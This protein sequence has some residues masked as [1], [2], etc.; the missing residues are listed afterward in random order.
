MAG[1][2]DPQVEEKS[3][4]EADAVKVKGAEAALLD[5]VPADR[6]AAIEASVTATPAPRSREDLLE[7]AVAAN[8]RGDA[9]AAE[10]DF[11][12]AH[13]HYAAAANLIEIAKDR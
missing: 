12:A 1:K 3:E 11:T 13:D 2:F 4:S 7:S 5:E 6:K 8:A 10:G 9:A